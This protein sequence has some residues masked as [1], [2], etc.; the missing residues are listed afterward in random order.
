VS[1]FTDDRPRPH[2]YQFTHRVL[3]G[4][5]FRTTEPFRSAALAG[6]AE[7]GLQELWG[8]LD[9]SQ[10]VRATVHECAGRSVVLVTPPKAEHATE[11]HHI[12]IVLDQVDSSFVRYIVLEHGWDTE[13]QPR[14]VIGEWTR[15]GSHINF[16]DGP[17]AP[18]EAAFL[19]IV[20]ERF[21]G[22]PSS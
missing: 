15:G 13:S 7:P 2:Y 10:S 3:R 16:G 17:Q 1:K 11:A 21:T 19:A 5:L 14:T 4:M 8:H 6:R 20:C 12:A 18:D 9:A 22:D